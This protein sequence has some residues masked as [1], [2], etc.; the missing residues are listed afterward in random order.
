MR[1]IKTLGKQVLSKL[2]ESQVVRLRR[3]HDFTLLAV[4]GS[5]GKT[6]IKTALAT[7]LAT[8][9]TVRYQAGNYNDRLTV[10][11]VFFGHAEPPIFAV[12]RWLKVLIDNERQ[13]RR[14]YPFKTV[15][16]E[17]GPDGPGQMR[18]FAYLQP[19]LTVLTAITPEHMEF[20]K[21]MDAVAAEELMV[22]DY[23]KR[24]LVN[25]DLVSPKYLKGR[26]AVT[27]GTTQHVAY[28]LSASKP[29]AD[30]QHLT[31]S[32]K[33][34]AHRA[35]T[36]LLGV[37]GASVATAVYATAIELGYD[38]KTAA[39]LIPAI[40]PV[41]GRAQVL[42]GV[43][44]ATI[45]DDTYNAST[46]SMIAALE[47]LY[48]FKA[49]QRI[50]ILGS[51]NELGE[52]SPEAHRQ[53]GAA[54]DPS[55]L[56]L[57]VTVGQDAE[58]YLAPEAQANGVVVVSFSNPYEAGDYVRKHLEPGAVILGKGSQN[59]IY[60]EEALKKLLAHNYDSSRLVRQSPYWLKRKASQFG[61][62][63][64]P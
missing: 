19:D 6:S 63:A 7:A 26:T 9:G 2:L 35:V 29:A 34:H 53:V 21:T 39:H 25:A 51:M 17:L 62:V 60:V 40:K 22:F 48:S 16:V 13:I 30:G 44:D 15:V 14:D 59:L 33:G 18:H 56:S 61:H 5:V 4:A 42:K 50:A 1:F 31:I 46:V 45:I 27:Y 10:P 8:Q 12:F 23:S 52:T 3:K 47:T 41:A 54:C 38:A 11:L 57:L 20:F 28:H 24:V 32:F 64:K 58:T 37:P 43:K 49:A 36:N 55:M